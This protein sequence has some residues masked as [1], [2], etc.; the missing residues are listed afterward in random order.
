MFEAATIRSGY[1]LRDTAGFAD[2]IET[3]MRSAL[4]ISP[5]EKVDEMPDFDE[6]VAEE[7]AQEQPDE[8]NADEEPE[9]K[10]EVSF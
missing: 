2:R 1:E 3:M 8:V 7:A 5:D 4:N 9:V 6:S 10:A